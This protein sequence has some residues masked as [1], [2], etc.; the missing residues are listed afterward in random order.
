MFRT[1]LWSAT[2]LTVA[3]AVGG[4]Q[5]SA[6][7]LVFGR[8]T[9]QSVL[10]PHYTVQPTGVAI[11]TD[12]YDRLVRF[13]LDLQ[14]EPGLALSWKPLDEMTW[15]IKLRPEVVFHDGST[16]DAADV[17]YS[18]ERASSMPE[19][20]SP[21]SVNVAAVERVEVID[22][23]TLK[24]VTK[25]PTPLL[26]NQIGHVFI[27][28][29]ELGDATTADFN[30]G[31]AAIGTGPYKFVSW[32]PNENVEVEAFR[33][34]WG[35]APEWDRVRMQFIT[36]PAAR[37]AALLS[38]QVD[39][40][41]AVPPADVPM[42]KANADLTVFSAPSVRLLYMHLDLANDNSPWITDTEGNP[43]EVNPLKDPKV[44]KALSLMLNRQ[45]I[46]DRIMDGLAA[47]AGQVAAPG[48]GGFSDNMPPDPYDVDQARALLAEAGYPDGFGMTLHCATDRDV[49]TAESAQAIAQMWARG[50]IKINAVDCQPYSVYS[51]A[52]TKGEFSA[53]IWGR[54]D[55]SPDTSL[56]LRNGYM[57]YDA[58]RGFGSY[59]RGRYSNQEFDA[60][61][62]AAL[63]E[64]DQ[65]T[66][67]QLLRD[68]TDIMIGEH[69]VIP[70]YFLNAT[71]ATRGG[72]TFD[73]NMA[74]N[75]MI[76][77]V[78]PAD[79]M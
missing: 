37:T 31:A 45:A 59:N 51:S 49:N 43:L 26:M 68:A 54:N 41:D 3:A 79:A 34:Y 47:P 71:W 35:P 11:A 65:E 22:D 66:R 74:V 77:Y 46:A 21:M 15:E 14:L 38:G 29:S 30:S 44:R 61:V 52:A 60:L 16:F 8:S 4:V 18:L 32:I 27:T 69:G 1:K 2:A 5:A 9:P 24:I 50:G 7:D 39:V 33:D 57:T 48:Q 10:D 78:H 75:S 73:A 6:S 28:P 25:E 64:F 55:S 72:I 58:D 42:L 62:A 20:P 53:F 23:L 67:Y 17:A 36:D 19:S 56:N 13:G 12:I 40:I 63:Q 76:Q 70:L